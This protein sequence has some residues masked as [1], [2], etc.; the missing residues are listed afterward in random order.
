M[1]DRF[2]VFHASRKFN[3]AFFFAFTCSNFTHTVSTTQK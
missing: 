1:N 2:A 3:F